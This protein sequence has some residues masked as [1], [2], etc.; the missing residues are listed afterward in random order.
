MEAVRS[1]ID[2]GQFFAFGQK[3]LHGGYPH[4][5]ASSDCCAECGIESPISMRA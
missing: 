1:E 3:C 4:N 2:C 5:R